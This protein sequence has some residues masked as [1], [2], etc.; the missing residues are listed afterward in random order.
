MKKLVILYAQ[1]DRSEFEKLRQHLSLL[2]KL[3]T[4]KVWHE[5]DI[6]AGTD[7]D[8][9]THAAFVD[10]ESVLLLVSAAFLADDHCY[11]LMTTARNMGKPLIPIILKDCL[12]QDAPFGQLK[13]LPENG[14][15]VHDKDWETPEEPYRQI[16]AYLRGTP[17]TESTEP[18]ERPNIRRQANP[19]KINRNPLYI[20]IGALVAVIFVLVA[21]KRNFSSQGTNTS[22]TNNTTNTIPDT[23]TK[24]DAKSL[25]KMVEIPAGAFTMGNKDSEV[26]GEKPAHKVN[27]SRFSLSRY[28]ITVREFNA[29]VVA[30]KYV[31]DAERNGGTYYYNEK[32]LKSTVKADW[33]CDS[34]YQPYKNLTDNTNAVIHVSYNDA[35]AYCNWLSK[36]TGETYRL[37]TEAEWEYAARAGQSNDGPAN[38]A[39]EAWYGENSNQKIHAVGTKQANRFGLH[40]MLGNAYEWCNDWFDDQYY[41]NSSA[42]NP[43][44]PS[45]P[46]HNGQLRVGRGGSWENNANDISFSKR[47]NETPDYRD[48]LLGFRVA[49]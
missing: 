26:A 49:L 40:D 27:I 22:S 23:N 35:I 29:F 7:R 13:V 45:K 21:I 47:G 31:S 5:G 37:P 16:A 20:G 17:R 32:G 33:R 11:D 44:G 36:S 48:K 9:A 18:V 28:E 8:D 42:N 39:A 24:A 19:T 4:I 46:G 15:P 25:P 12:W 3:Q 1:E 6:A 30:T 14:T 2:E 41:A 10:A 43:Q 38:L 34:D